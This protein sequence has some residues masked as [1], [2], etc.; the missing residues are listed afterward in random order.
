MFGRLCKYWFPLL[1][2]MAVIF[3]A[4]T[5]LGAP[6]HTSRFIIPILLWFDPHMSKETIE[7]VHHAI[8]KCAHFTEYAFLGCLTWRLLRNDKAFAGVTPSRQYWVAI[9]FCAFYAATDEFHQKFVPTRQPAVLDV[10]LDTC[11]AA[12]GLLAIWCV[13]LWGKAR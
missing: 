11:G 8:R 5:S 3:S 1:I 2:W 6:K 7:L 9:L 10:M 13:R 4:S 12:F